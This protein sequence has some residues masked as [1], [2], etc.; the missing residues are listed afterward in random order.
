[1]KKERQKNPEN[2]NIKKDRQKRNSNYRLTTKKET[3]GQKD[4]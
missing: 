4:K 1:L 2:T 3:N